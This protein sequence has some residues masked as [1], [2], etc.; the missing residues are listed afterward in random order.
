MN[1]N[2]DQYTQETK[3]KKNIESGLDGC[4]YPLL[5]IF[6]CNNELKSH[7]VFQKIL[8]DWLIY[9]EKKMSVKIVGLL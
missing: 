3:L 2:K 9:N 1:K 8:L 6:K 7:V 5:S 4:G